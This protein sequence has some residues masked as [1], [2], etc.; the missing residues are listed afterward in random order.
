MES[1]DDVLGEEYVST[2]RTELQDLEE[3]IAYEGRWIEAAQTLIKHEKYQEVPES[4]L[5]HY[6]FDGEV[7]E[8][9]DD[10]D[11]EYYDEACCGDGVCRCD[12][13]EDE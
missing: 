7:D 11:D 2:I 13:D 8:L 12:D 6:F 5:S 1:A 9:S 3:A 4:F 10:D